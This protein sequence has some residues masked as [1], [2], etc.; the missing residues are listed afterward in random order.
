MNTTDSELL[1]ELDRLVHEV[2]APNAPKVDA[3]GAFPRESIDALANAGLLAVM[4]AKAVGGLELGLPTAVQV[5]ECV[6]RAC[7]ST[8][9]CLTMH[10]CGVA[11]IEQYGPESVR[12]HIAQ[13]LHLSTLAFSEATSRSQFWAPT[14]TAR[15]TDGKIRLDAKKSFVTSAHHATAYVWSS[16]PLSAEG[17]STIWLVPAS[18]PGLA[19]VG[20]F[21]GLGLRGNDSAPIVA[22]GALVEESTRLGS[23]GGGFDMMMGTVLPNFQLLL[24]GVSLGVME[25]AVARTIDHAK[26]TKFEHLG[27]P[28]CDQPV[29]R[30]HIARMRVQTDLVR[31]LLLDAVAAVSDRRAD[32]GLRVL[33]SKLAA[34]DTAAA[35]LDLAMRVCGGAAFRKEVGVERLFRDARAATIMAPTSDALLEFIAR[36]VCGLPLA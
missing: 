25:A 9:M 26:A 24:A 29:T 31:G 22:D 17:P 11:V 5:V 10:Y 1:A 6:A 33:E 23:D 14:S 35:V 3:D 16:R 21:D 4:S 19:V 2:I 7:A 18:T 8:A 30:H 32:A 28:L 27:Q 36:A 34:G 13:G 12:K 20:R 15:R